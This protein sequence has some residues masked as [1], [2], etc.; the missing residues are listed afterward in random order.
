MKRGCEL[1][2]VGS[3]L[4]GTTAA[5]CADSWTAPCVLGAG[6]AAA[7]LA[8]FRRGGGR[9]MVVLT[10]SGLVPTGRVSNL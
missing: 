7:A 3:E 9:A 8:R 1:D 2:V 10:F 5:K 6:W 4:G